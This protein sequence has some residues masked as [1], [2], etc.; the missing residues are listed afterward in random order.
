MELEAMTGPHP[1]QLQIDRLNVANHFIC[2]ATFWTSHMCGL[3]KFPCRLYMTNLAGSGSGLVM[4]AH[5][6]LDEYLWIIDLGEAERMRQQVTDLLDDLESNLREAL[7]VLSG[8]R[9][10]YDER[11]SDSDPSNS[12]PGEDL[13][14]PNCST[15]IQQIYIGIKEN[16]SCLYELSIVLRNPAPRDIILKLATIDVS[17]TSRSGTR[18]MWKELFYEL[19]HSCFNGLGNEIPSGEKYDELTN[20]GPKPIEELRSGLFKN[21]TTLNTQTTR[22][23]SIE[24][25]KD[26]TIN[27]I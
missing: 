11:Q 21:A 17:H 18:N 22:S 8:K 9:L 1:L 20:D 7:A 15:E 19:V 3:K 14:A 23:T 6:V 4:L 13:E 24:N 26:M 16:I 25:N 10:P 5:I 2:F 12:S 27:E